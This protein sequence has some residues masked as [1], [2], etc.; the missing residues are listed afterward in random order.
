MGRGIPGKCLDM[1]E[2][3]QEHPGSILRD[4]L[5]LWLCL[6]GVWKNHG[7]FGIP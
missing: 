6:T 7:M 1:A 5:I 4:F 3:H 2:V